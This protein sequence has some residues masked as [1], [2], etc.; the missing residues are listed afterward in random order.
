MGR[1]ILKLHM[2]LE[3]SVT[4]NYFCLDFHRTSLGEG[5]RKRLSGLEF[6]AKNL[7]LINW[8]SSEIKLCK[9]KGCPSKLHS[10]VLKN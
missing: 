9:M 5:R 7:C 1:Y 3:T 8:K 6:K 10:F 4:K 2:K